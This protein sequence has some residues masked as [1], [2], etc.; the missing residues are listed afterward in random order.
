MPRDEMIPA[1]IYEFMRGCWAKKPNERPTFKELEEKLGMFGSY[2]DQ[3]H[4]G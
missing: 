2:D 3:N 4:S 1:D